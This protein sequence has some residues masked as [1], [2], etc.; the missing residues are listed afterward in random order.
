[1]GD[2]DS[3]EAALDSFLDWARHEKVQDQVEDLPAPE[4]VQVGAGSVLGEFEL[5]RELGA[6]GM[7]IVYEARQLSYFGRRVAVK[8]LR[9]LFS[10]KRLE[11]RFRREIDA[12]SSLDH[13][14]IVPIVAAGVERGVPFYAMKFVEGM[15]AARLVRV[16]K[17]SAKL[18]PDVRD[19]RR[20][21]DLIPERP[22]DVFDPRAVEELG[23]PNAW[24]E[25]YD[26][27]VARIGMLVAEALQHAHGQEVLHRDVKPANVVVTPTG[28]PVLLD[29]GL[30]NR[31][32]DT[33]LTDTGDFLGTLA[34]AAPEQVR[35]EPVDGRCDVYSLGA[36]LY[37]LLSLRRPFE[38]SNRSELLR[39]IE[40]KDVPPL[41]DWI[42]LPLRTIVECCLARPS[43]R[44]YASAAALAHDLRSFL[45]GKPIRAKPRGILARVWETTRRH[46]VGLVLAFAT[47][48]FAL[49]FL[50]GIQERRAARAWIVDGDVRLAHALDARERLWTATL[51]PDRFDD[52]RCAGVYAPPRPEDREMTA[53]LRRNLAEELAAAARSYRRAFEHVS[54]YAPAMR[55]LAALHSAELRM[56]L[57]DDLDVL[58]P[59][60]LQRI[61]ES[62][63]RFERFV[64]PEL[65]DPTGRVRLD[66]V[67]TG[68]S[69]SIYRTP[70]AGD[71]ERAS[72][73]SLR[74]P[75]ELDGL[76]EGSY[77]A[78]IRSVGF[79]PTVYPFLVRRD[80]RASLRGGGPRNEHRVELLESAVVPPEF[81][82]VPA[83]WTLCHDDPQRW[84]RVEGFCVQ[85]NEV[86]FGD[87]LR[88]RNELPGA[89]EHF[90][91]DPFDPS[92]RFVGPGGLSP[93]VRAD[94][95][96]YGLTRDEM[97]SYVS[98]L[99]AS[100]RLGESSWYFSLPT[101]AEWIRAARGADA[102]RFPWGDD[103]SWDRC[104]G[105]PSRGSSDRVDP[106][107]VDAFQGDVSP[108]GVRNLAG[109]VTEA[110]M[111]TFPTVRGE[112]LFCGGSHRKTEQ[113]EMRVTAMR[114][115]LNQPRLDAGF[116]VVLRRLPA[117][118]NGASGPP[119]V[120]RDDFERE[121]SSELGNGWIECANHPLADRVDPNM[122]DPGHVAGGQLVL[123]GGV[124]HF[125]EP[126]S[127]YRPLAVSSAG[128]RVR[129]VLR[130]ERRV[131][132]E[133]RGF[134]LKLASGLRST[135]HA[136]GLGVSFDGAPTLHLSG[137]RTTRRAELPP[138][139]VPWD[140]PLE[141]ELLLRPDRLEGRVWRPG[142]PRPE[143]PT[144][145]LLD[146]DSPP[147]FPLLLLQGQNL[148]GVR[149]EV[150]WVE[151]VPAE[152]DEL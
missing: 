5:G 135:D 126:A 26:R 17:E 15:S 10:S 11:E 65:L 62:L 61:T 141:F 117:W 3:L 25:S 75:L 132:T 1:M 138:G 46:A 129:A 55:A 95:P 108:F 58:A 148:V 14:G 33:N 20:L 48:L 82:H 57:E 38:G 123:Q 42:P 89:L 97:T 83:G 147:A 146:L 88:L 137:P 4:L 8:V 39:Q 113:D 140:G 107:P 16:L 67:P 27:C 45:A 77:L 36:M 7:G 30:A 60:R 76:P 41:D 122:T 23:S 70:L 134:G 125:S 56:A 28:R 112:F 73:A 79:A 64:D 99:Q 105:F 116:R 18:P 124:D 115:L 149:L 47:G 68:A 144:L 86:T 110:T 100:A 37:E 128:L 150:D 103:F 35:G 6:G 9:N 66:T 111:G 142:L 121:D 96:V 114:G 92:V 85:R 93:G 104:A 87:W 94:W 81:V 74:S 63:D 40:T 51:R 102:R 106:F 12:I 59:E 72:V 52:W 29:F 44:R 13:P 131:R 21:F 133:G 152:L 34:Y 53:T 109:S 50:D 54:D 151:V 22:P 49:A 32:Q 91:R 90:P 118:A 130:A 80:V 31:A 19:V 101:R 69:V 127:A 119:R 139:S 143:L 71:H 78:V 2:S 24:E 120:F 145:E 84:E 98:A 43:S 136:L